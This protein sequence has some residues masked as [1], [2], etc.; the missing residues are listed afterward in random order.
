MLYF[1]HDT[2][3]LIF[4]L[5]KIENNQLCKY[6]WWDY[7]KRVTTAGVRQQKDK[8]NILTDGRIK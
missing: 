4:I 8:V 7:T 1:T 3:K 5:P 2:N 6:T